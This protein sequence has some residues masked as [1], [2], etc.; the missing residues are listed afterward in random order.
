[1]SSPRWSPPPDRLRRADR[2]APANGGTYNNPHLHVIRRASSPGSRRD[3][4]RVADRPSP[5]PF[6]SRPRPGGEAVVRREPAD[7]V[8]AERHVTIDLSTSGWRKAA[9][10]SGGQTEIVYVLR[11]KVTGEYLKVGKT[12]TSSLIG[13]FEKYR[14][15]GVRRGMRL[16]AD[17]YTLAED[18]V[19]TVETFEGEMRRGLM[20][21][22]E[23]LRWDNSL[24][25]RPGKGI[26]APANTPF[27]VEGPPAAAPAGG[28]AAG[29]IKPGSTPAT[30]ASLGEAGAAETMASPKPGATPASP[31]AAA[32]GKELSFGRALLGLA[33]VAG[34]LLS[35]MAAEADF[36]QEDYVGGTLD[37]AAATGIIAP[38]VGEVAAPAAVAWEGIKSYGELAAWEGQCRILAAKFETGQI[39]NSE[40]EDLARSCPETMIG[41]EEWQRV[42]RAYVNDEWP[43]D[44]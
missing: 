3:V 29:A 15:E 25:T 38:A 16:E 24:R 4:R 1:M 10:F 27:S 13:R 21:A 33:Q 14:T 9:K 2:T 30:S 43:G 28:P 36:E 6:P 20:N 23:K 5:S 17:V 8:I 34:T 39:S 12:T 40:F 41:R 7:I 18:P 37:T 35:A 11:D 26:P 22:G 32:A 42:M 44:Y 31:L 19:R